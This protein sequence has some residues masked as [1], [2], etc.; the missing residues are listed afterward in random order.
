MPGVE[1]FGAESS[2][3][4]GISENRISKNA[5]VIPVLKKGILQLRAENLPELQ[6]LSPDPLLQ[7]GGLVLLCPFENLPMFWQRW[8]EE[9]FHSDPCDRRGC[10][11]TCL[12]LEGNGCYLSGAASPPCWHCPPKGPNLTCSCVGGESQ[13]PGFPASFPG[14]R[15][16]DA[17]VQLLCVPCLWRSKNNFCFYYLSAPQIWNE[18]KPRN[19]ILAR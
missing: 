16:T 10:L 19:Y 2:K 17:V 9:G 8:V 7:H 14:G 1:C 11:G 13:F 3:W 15:R 6:A 18:L 5:L 12:L 4:N